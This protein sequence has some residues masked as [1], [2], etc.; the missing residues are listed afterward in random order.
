MKRVVHGLGIL[1]V[2][3]VSGC[4]SAIDAPSAYETA[5]YLCD[6]AHRATWDAEVEA[7]RDAHLSTQSCGGVI[8]L[9]GVIDEQPVVV[10]LRAYDTVHSIDSLDDEG[11][12]VRAT[13]AAGPTP[14]FGF[15]IVHQFYLDGR[16]GVPSGQTSNMTLEARGGNYLVGFNATSQSIEVLKDDEVAFRLTAKLSRGGNIEGCF[17]LFPMTTVE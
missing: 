1:L 3:A 15:N 11:I 6:D 17:H 16:D 7:C 2:L 4:A 9:R 13:R 10:T 8:S 12:L 5:K 14:Y